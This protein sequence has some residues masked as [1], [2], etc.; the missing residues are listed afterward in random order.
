MEEQTSIDTKIYGEIHNLVLSSFY[1]DVSGKD[2]VSFDEK[3]NLIDQFL[4]ENLIEV[5]VGFFKDFVNNNFELKSL[6]EIVENP[7]N[8]DSETALTIIDDFFFEGKIGLNEK[9]LLTTMVY[10]YEEF[11]FNFSAL[12]IAISDLEIITMED[13]NISIEEKEKLS[14]IFSITKSSI[15]FWEEFEGFLPDKTRRW[16]VRDLTGAA[17]AIYSGAVGYASIAFGPWGGA[18]V[19]I[20]VAAFNSAVS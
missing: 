9:S 10:Y 2:I 11:P 16:Y 17:T 6:M 20:G 18:A 13:P 4:S 1:K 3:L 14:K 19:L 8:S 5:E 12:K 15:E 7:S